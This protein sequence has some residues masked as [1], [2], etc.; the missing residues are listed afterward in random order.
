MSCISND[1]ENYNYYNFQSFLGYVLHRSRKED[2]DITSF[3]PL[4]SINSFILKLWTDFR[5]DELLELNENGNNEKKKMIIYK[6]FFVSYLISLLT[7]I[8]DQKCD[9]IEIDVRLGVKQLCYNFIE[10]CQSIKVSDLG[11]SKLLQ[12]IEEQ[13][14]KRE[15]RHQLK[16]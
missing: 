11:L 12:N 7:K 16:M 1:S 9:K 2:I 14:I 4:D 5:E 8:L 10:I 13:N 15:E 6:F 3:M